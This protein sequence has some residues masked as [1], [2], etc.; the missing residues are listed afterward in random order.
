MTGDFTI[1]GA[2]A[3]GAIV[4]VHLMRAGHS[5]A[6]IEANRA[7]VA[8]I[9]EGGLRLTGALD[10][11]VRPQVVLPAETGP[12]R[13]VLLAVKSRH[14]EDALATIAPQLAA[15]GYVVSLQNGL[16]EYK[17]AR[18]VGATRT[19]GAFLTFGGHYREPGLVVYGGPGSFRIG[20]L[21]GQT[22]KRLETLRAA[23]ASLQ[24]V[25]ITPN[26]FGCLWAKMSLGAIYNATA[27][28]SADVS[29]QYG[30]AHYRAL[31]ARLCGEVVAVADAAGVR[32][33]PF[34]GF[35]PAV[36][37]PG[38]VADDAAIAASWDGQRRYWNRHGP[39][40]QRTGVWRDL[41]IHKRKT[42]IDEMI[43]AVRKVARERAVATPLLDALT[44]MV[45]EVEDGKRELGYHNLDALIARAQT[46]PPM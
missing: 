35:D 14:T 45:H 34:D 9:R 19:I 23:L 41:A 29:E 43:G 15:D 32:C 27:L 25:E 16:E 44:A 5:V 36:F 42:E 7:H 40:A 21:D 4:G 17:I 2:G 3:I 20:E 31:F 8:A 11:V 37:R 10:A 18:A 6:Y 38:A 22:T 30:H 46:S 13:Q 12:L 26:I 1:V 28:V 39:G 24:P 33:E